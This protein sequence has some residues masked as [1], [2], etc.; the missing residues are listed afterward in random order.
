MTTPSGDIILVVDDEQDVREVV[1]AC[2]QKAGYDTMLASNGNAGYAILEQRAKELGDVR[3][4]AIVSDWMM[5]ELS[6]VEF[7]QRVRNGEFKTLPFVLMSG[8]VTREDLILALRIGADSIVLKPFTT[9][10]LIKKVQEAMNVRL[11]KE[12]QKM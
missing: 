3:V 7:L 1:A 6:G 12:L 5:P 2:L 8:A 10:A 4:A 9:D 11:Q